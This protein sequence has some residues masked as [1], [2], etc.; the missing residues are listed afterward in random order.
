MRAKSSFHFFLVLGSY[1]AGAVPGSAQHLLPETTASS[2]STA[3]TWLFFYPNEGRVA[4]PLAIGPKA[5]ERRF[6]AAL[7]LTA[8]DYPVHPADVAAVRSMG[9][10]VVGAS[11][12]LNAV[13]VE[14]AAV[15]PLP[16]CIRTARALKPTHLTSATVGWDQSDKGLTAYQYA[17][18]DNAIAQINGKGLHEAFYEGQGMLIAVLDG[19]FRDVDT[20]GAFTRLRNENRL[21]FTKDLVE[22]DDSVYE[23]SYHGTAVLSTMAPDL[24]GIHV[25]TAPKAS[26]ALFKTENVYSETPLE[27]WNWIRGAEMADSIGADVLNTSLGY[28]TFDDPADNHTYADMDGRTTP[29]SLAAV[30]LARS[31]LLLVVSAGNEGSGTWK[32]ITAPADADSVLTVGAVNVLGAKA[33]FSSQ[34]PTSDG[35]IKPDVM[36]LGQGCGIIN[37]GGVP[38]T[39]N[40]TSFS[41]PVMAGMMACLWQK[42]PNRSA[43][44]LLFSIRLTASQGLTPDTLY[45]HGIPDFDLASTVLGQEEV[46]TLQSQVWATPSGWYG[47]LPTAASGWAY[48]S[49]VGVD[50][51]LLGHWNL[52]V[53]QGRWEIDESWSARSPEKVFWRIRFGD[54]T[55]TGT[56]LS[57]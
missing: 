25:G 48:A 20:F 42:H 9:Y 38:G 34:G 54:R 26:Y 23:D 3:Y 7:P 53:D 12:L 2:E 55:W 52:L 57:R 49:A 18:G 16:G 14:G 8:S 39:A 35:R 21:V 33:G 1:L 27:E 32:Y 47:E 40:G 46:G 24:D 56:A 4:L 29:I 44:D 17:N 37:S 11:R 51:R 13:V 36:A 19:G 5:L 50:G 45:G 30:A 22:N 6:K 28:S 31:G 10:R 43:Q 41:G 15:L